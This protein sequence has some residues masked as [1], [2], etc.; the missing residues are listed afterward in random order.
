MDTPSRPCSQRRKWPRL[1]IPPAL[2]LLLGATWWYAGRDRGPAGS[3]PP[4]LPS[5][6]SRPTATAGPTP[7]PETAWP[8]ARLEGEP[9]KQRLV[10]FLQRTSER[11]ERVEGYTARFRKQERINGVLGP[12]QVMELKLRQRPFA[13]YLKY[14]GPKAGREVVYADGRHG[15]K[16]VAHN[17]DWTR[18]LIPRLALNPA[19]P[20]A[21]ADCRHPIT[22]AGLAHLTARLLATSRVNLGDP[23]SVTVLDRVTD[24]DGREWLRSAQVYTR[25]HPERPFVRVEILYDPASGLPL[26][27]SGYDSPEPVAWATRSS[28]TLRL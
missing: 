25:P 23:G 22:E 13:V 24:G 17:G 6:L 11:L 5:A 10:A 27:V 4:A 28:A 8:A 2:L 7:A 14:L 16:L 21:M 20:L 1:V 19:D 26:R 15:N 9:A 12:E 18:R 3:L